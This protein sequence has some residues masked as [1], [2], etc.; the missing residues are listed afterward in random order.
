MHIEPDN[1]INIIQEQLDT[2]D[3]LSLN[4][5]VAQLPEW[6]SLR[7]L[8]ILAALERQ[9]GQ[10]IALQDFLRVQTISDLLILVNAH[11]SSD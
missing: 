7:A 5:V 9:L 2:T 1:I 11:V 4:T 8:R 10:K 3:E 6:D